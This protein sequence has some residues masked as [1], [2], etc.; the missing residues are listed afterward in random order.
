[1]KKALIVAVSFCFIGKGFT[2][3]EYL[4]DE[5]NQGTPTPLSG[6]DITDMKISA[7]LTYLTE[8]YPGAADL[9]KTPKKTFWTVLCESVMA[10]DPLTAFDERAAFALRLQTLV[11]KH[12]L[13]DELTNPSALT[14]L[15]GL[16]MQASQRDLDGLFYSKNTFK[17]YIC[18][19]QAT[20]FLKEARRMDLVIWG[21]QGQ[22]IRGTM[23][24]VALDP[25]DDTPYFPN[26]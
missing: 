19:A 18:R 1:M 7:H 12:A 6:P 3:F 22:M 24:D 20:H 10:M 23:C 4:L 5:T 25:K 8:R 26:A 13:V 21:P 9:F 15:L 17:R 11:D 2:S 14:P 16:L